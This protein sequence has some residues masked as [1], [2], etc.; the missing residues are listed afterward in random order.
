MHITD[1]LLGQLNKDHFMLI[2]ENVIDILVKPCKWVH[3]HLLPHP[4]MGKNSISPQSFGINHE[5][6][7]DSDKT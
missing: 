1:C 3:A 4:G 7:N 6:N 5:N 2:R